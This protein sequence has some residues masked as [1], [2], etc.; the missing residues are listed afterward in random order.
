MPLNPYIEFFNRYLLHFT[1]SEES[2]SQS[3]LRS[4]D[5]N[6]QDPGFFHLSC[7]GGVANRGSSFTATATGSI[8]FFLSLKLWHE[9]KLGRQHCTDFIGFSFSV[10]GWSPL[11]VHSLL[12]TEL[13]PQGVP[14]ADFGGRPSTDCKV[15]RAWMFPLAMFWLPEI[16]GSS[17]SRSFRLLSR[18]SSDSFFFLSVGDDTGTE[19][20]ILSSK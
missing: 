7:T 16:F 3:G 4:C 5:P 20:G 14:C 1:K 13:V 8:F 18:K 10:K 9:I 19:P 2:E 15:G 17:T 11:A 12:H 6:I